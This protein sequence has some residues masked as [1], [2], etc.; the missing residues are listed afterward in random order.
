MLEHTKGQVDMIKTNIF[1]TAVCILFFIKL[2]WPSNKSSHHR[3]QM[4][5]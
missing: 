2:R 4:V 3:Q 5:F 1:I